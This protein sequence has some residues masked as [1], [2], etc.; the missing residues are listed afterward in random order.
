MMIARLK[1]IAFVR[2]DPPRAVL[3]LLLLAAHA[4]R[5]AELVASLR[6]ERVIDS[7]LRRSRT[8]GYYEHLLNASRGPDR[9]ARGGVAINPPPGVIPFRDAGIVEEV[10]TYLRWRMRADLDLRWNGAI[11]RTNRFGFR[12]P[13]VDRVKPGGTYRIILFGSSNTM[14]H[15]V[16]DDAIYPRHLE[17][18]LNEQVGPSRRVEVVN[19][20]ISGDSPTRRLQ[21]IREEA[22]RFDADWLLCDA[23]AFDFMLEQDHLQAIVRDASPIPF[24]FVRDVLRR[25]GVS[26]SDS[27]ESLRRKLADEC[28]SL[29]D[30]AYAGWRAEASRLGIPISVVILP[31]SDKKIASPRMFRLIRTLADRHG[32]ESFDLTN[33]FRDLAEEE[34]PVSRWDTHPGVRAHLAI[35][36]AFRAE[37]RRRGALP[38]LPVPLAR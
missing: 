6:G 18:W 8:E 26:A 36:E 16:D 2:R 10:P 23:S 22:G 3:V 34:I 9:G 7:D 15:G 29:L 24:D 38:G 20:A 11:F 5:E 21:R 30:G 12:S 33:A 4:G 17:R 27:P 31:R 35:F 28:E 25:A 14:G 37:L 13:E 32:M 1:I 19:L